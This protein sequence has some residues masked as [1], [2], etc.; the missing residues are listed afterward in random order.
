M[1]QSIFIPC[2]TYYHWHIFYYFR[3]YIG[4]IVTIAAEKSFCLQAPADHLN[5]YF[6]YFSHSFC[7]ALA[8][9]ARMMRMSENVAGV[10]LVAF[11]N[12][13]PDIFSSLSYLQNNTRRLYADI[14]AS[15]LFVVLIVAGIIFYSFPFFAQPYLL[16]RDAL[17]L[18]LD[19]CV[20]DYIIKKDSAISVGDSVGEYLFADTFNHLFFQI[21]A[22]TNLFSFRHSLHLPLLPFCR[23]I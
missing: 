22:N 16:L 21:L 12:G 2:A 6:C 17:F 11:G 1:G 20:I 15:A 7:P 19:V 3:C 5:F 14:L 4:Y 13:A 9:L 23:H 18:L 8:V 10:T